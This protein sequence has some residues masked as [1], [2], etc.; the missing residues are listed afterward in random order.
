MTSFSTCAR[1][2]CHNRVEYDK[3]KDTY[4]SRYCACCEDEIDTRLRASKQCSD[5]EIE[6]ALLIRV[7]R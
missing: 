5:E 1:T 7:V 6:A 3:T 4:R 2:G